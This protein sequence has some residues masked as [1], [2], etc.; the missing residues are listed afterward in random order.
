MEIIGW[1]STHWTY[2]PT[3]STVILKK[4]PNLF[5]TLKGFSAGEYQAQSHR[6][7]L[8]LSNGTYLLHHN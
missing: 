5:R 7:L 4:K 1:E 6:S 3:I 8:H 2:L